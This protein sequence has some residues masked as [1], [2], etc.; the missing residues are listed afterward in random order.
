[1]RASFKEYIG[2]TSQEFP[3]RYCLLSRLTHV[4]AQSPPTITFLG[5]DSLQRH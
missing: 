5:K 1:V 3:D 2:G 4:S